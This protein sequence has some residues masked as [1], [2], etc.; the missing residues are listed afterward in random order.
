MN[1]KNQGPIDAYA[2]TGFTA[3]ILL[4]KSYVEEKGLE[5]G[6]KINEEPIPISVADGH[7][8]DADSF[9][10]TIKIDGIEKEIEVLVEDTKKFFKRGGGKPHDVEPLL[11][12]D[13][14]DSFDVIFKGTERKIAFFE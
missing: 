12:R 7:L 11:G 3:G 4:T 10:M 9:K 8:I 5:L 14:L 13:F 2:D 1:P 6:E